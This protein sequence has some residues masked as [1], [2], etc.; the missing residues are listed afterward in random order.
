MDNLLSIITFMPMVAAL[1]L[2]FF[3]VATIRQRRQMPNGWR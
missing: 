3:C 1:I 2:A